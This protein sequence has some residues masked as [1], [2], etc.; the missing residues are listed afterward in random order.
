MIKKYLL[1]AILALVVVGG[2]YLFSQSNQKYGE[3]E[4]VATET[5]VPTP[6]G[7]KT[8][9]SSKNL[10]R[11]VLAIKDDAVR[12]DTV[13]SILF[14]VKEIMVLKQGG[15]WVTVVSKPQTFDLLQLKRDGRFVLLADVNI[16]RGNY[17]QVRLV[18][19]TVVVVKDG[20]AYDAKLPSGELKIVTDVDVAGSR[21]AAMTFD[22]LADKS[23]HSTG[24]GKYI[25]SPVIRFNAYETLEDVQILGKKVD[26]FGGTPKI[27]VEVGMD[28]NGD[29]GV[30]KSINPAAKLDLIKSGLIVVKTL[31]EHDFKIT[32]EAAIDAAIA[33]KYIDGALSVRMAKNS[34][35]H[36]PSWLVSGVKSF[37]RVLVEVDAT[38]GNVLSAK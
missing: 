7:G 24:N 16:E 4:P 19:G 33:G 21:A 23:L 27:N 1:W 31:E 12:L 20:I 6:V 32:A 30:G 17:S 11:L 29:V 28:E 2:V 3:G 37:K 35:T 22:V 25:F 9:V 8:T 36:L 34:E 26:L 18:I 15:G 14:N 10:G 38:T 5:S 13:Q